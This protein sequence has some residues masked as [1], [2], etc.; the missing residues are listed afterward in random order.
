MLCSKSRKENFKNAEKP[1]LFE[2]NWITNHF[3]ELFGAIEKTNKVLSTYVCLGS[4]QLV[5][6]VKQHLIVQCTLLCTSTRFLFCDVSS[7]YSC[8]TGVM[9]TR[10]IIHAA[11]K[12]V[13]FFEFVEI[14]ETK[15]LFMLTVTTVFPKA[16]Y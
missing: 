7:F 5:N 3:Q 6:Y 4:T 10:L 8:P 11:F 1:S 9:K 15:L 13:I 16:T 14:K 12:Q 2:I